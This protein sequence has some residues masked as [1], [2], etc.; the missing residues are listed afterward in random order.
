MNKSCKP[1]INHR[2]TVIHHHLAV[3]VIVLCNQKFQIMMDPLYL[4]I[5]IQFLNKTHLIIDPHMIEN[6]KETN[7]EEG[8]QE[9]DKSKIQI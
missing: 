2:Y 3:W 7:M 1:S 5:Q 4:N 9:E 6:M 8:I